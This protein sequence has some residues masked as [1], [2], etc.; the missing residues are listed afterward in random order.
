[1]S[2]FIFICL[3]HGFHVRN[4]VYS[5][6]YKEI[7]NNYKVV[8][9]IP[10]GVKIPDCDRYLLKGAIVESVEIEPHKFENYFLFF[11]KNVFAGRER[12]QTFNLISEIERK[13]HPLFYPL[14]NKLNA[15]FGHTPIVGKL[16]NRLEACFITGNEFSEVIDRYQPKLL[17]TANYGTEAFEVRLLRAAHKHEIPS[18][19]IIPSWDNLSSKGVIGENPMS[20]AVWNQIMRDEAIKLYDFKPSTVHICGG[21]QFD[22]YAEVQSEVEKE[23]IFCRLKIN[24]N[25]PF[26]VL[27]TITPKYFSKNIDI[28]DII[29]EAIETGKLHEE[30]QIVVRLHPQVIHDPIFGDDLNQ[31]YERSAQSSRI[32]LS[33]PEVLDWGSISPPSRTD[34]AELKALL[35]NAAVS[36]MPASTLAIDAAALDSPVIGIGFDGFEK[37]SYE[38]SVRRTFDFTHYKRLIAQGGLRIA[39]SSEELIKEISLYLDD[40][41]LD[42]EGRSRIV[43]T[44]LG[45]VD[46]MTWH[47]IA[48]VAKSLSQVKR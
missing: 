40:P 14:A 46:G 24:K 7:L 15:I 29:N 1:M 22:S 48:M 35:Q 8:I 9:I 5:L 16:W 47:R 33:I 43:E 11:R 25:R 4:I 10:N 31:Y 20:L 17:I 38:K 12:T 2:N 32:K 37:C 36:I 44:H 28:L 6:F 3:S 13:K 27:G 26:I 34:S 19:A 42:S 30:L 39:E 21:L 23:K 41:S 18:L 45:Q